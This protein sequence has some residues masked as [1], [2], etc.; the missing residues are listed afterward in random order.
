V[1]FRQADLSFATFQ[2]CDL[3]GALFEGSFFNRTVF[4]GENQL[5]GA[6][7]GDLSRLQSVFVGNG[8]SSHPSISR[9]GFRR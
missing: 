8:F 5:Q 9:S 4:A 2:E 1:S 6:K 3:R 7:F